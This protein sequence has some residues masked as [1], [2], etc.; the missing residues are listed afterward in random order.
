MTDTA[1]RMHSMTFR[2]LIDWRVEVIRYKQGSGLT[3]QYSTLF[4][5]DVVIDDREPRNEALE[6]TIQALFEQDRL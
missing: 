5:R 3:G 2:Y 4:G 6:A 1:I